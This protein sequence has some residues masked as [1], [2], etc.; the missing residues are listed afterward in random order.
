MP[1]DA[2]AMVPP[3]TDEQS[4]RSLRERCRNLLSGLQNRF[5]FFVSLPVITVIGSLLASHFQYLSAYQDKVDAE[6]KQQVSAAETTYTDVS[7]MFSKA[8]TLQQYLFFDF[9]DSVKANTFSDGHAL[10][11]T[12]ARAI[13]KQYDELRISLRQNIDLLARRVERDLDWRSD[14]E[15]DPANVSLVD[16][17]VTRIKLGAYN[18]ECESQD[19]PM[20]DFHP[21]ESNVA[22]P[23]PPEMLAYNPKAKPLRLDWYSA[24]HHVL[25]L[26]YCFEVAH[27]RIVAARQWA[28][29][30]TVDSAAADAFGHSMDS[31]QI[32]FN[33]EAERL[34]AFLTL[35]SRRI[36]IIQ[37]KFRP[38]PWVCHAPLIRELVDVYSKTNYC[39][40]I[41]VR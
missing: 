3:K 34:N 17:P 33:R 39:L 25:T 13:F 19:G 23:P 11:S 40:P 2:V 16:D 22:L 4:R 29:N 15:R 7:I 38:R 14:P 9:R 12:D 20:P 5:H 1:D 30:G 24:K 18:F 21:G 26:Y 32:S 10:N 37:V 35:A 6:A 31:I 27:R 41:R 36:E 28:A 8:I